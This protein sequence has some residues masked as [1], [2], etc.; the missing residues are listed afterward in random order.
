MTV[1]AN[2]NLPSEAEVYPDSHIPSGYR[3]VPG[4]PMLAVSEAGEVWNIKLNRPG[5]IQTS[6]GKTSKSSDYKFVCYA[7]GGGKSTSKYVHRMVAMAYIPV[8]VEL[9]EYI[10]I[11]QVNHIDGNKANNAKSNLEWVTA[12]GNIQ[13]VIENGLKT[14][15]KVLAK[16]LITGEVRE[17]LSSEHLAREYRIDIKKLRRHLDSEFAGYWSKDYWV[18][19][20]KHNG[21]DWPEVTEECVIPDRWERNYGVWVA[22]KI[23]CSETPTMMAATLDKI[24]EI[25]ELKYHSVQPEVRTDGNTW[26]VVGWEF[27]Y[28]SVPTKAMLEEV[29][30]KKEGKFREI[31]QVKVSVI[32]SQVPPTIYGS[33]RAAS[34]ATNVAL[35]S[36]TYVIKNKGG[37]LGKYKFE[38][39]GIVSAPIH[40]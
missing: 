10:D 13:H 11:L 5:K 18:F 24:C 38:F 30:Y 19:K 9:Q 25:T 26:K 20:Y 14:F 28:Y 39:T 21:K 29:V 7:I 40:G 17:F 8:P 22:K 32:G 1:I 31:R 33:M 34:K 36:I 27:T 16:H 35:T 15:N 37:V 3:R 12:K 2:L 6:G 4:V 23:D